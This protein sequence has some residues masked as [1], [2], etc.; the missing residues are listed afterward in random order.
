MNAPDDVNDD[1]HYPQDYGPDEQEQWTGPWFLIPSEALITRNPKRAYGVQEEAED[2]SERPT[3]SARTFEAI[4]KF[5]RLCPS[6][7]QAFAR[8]QHG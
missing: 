8:D 1:R 6:L 4:V 2:P 7:Q 5:L 3:Y